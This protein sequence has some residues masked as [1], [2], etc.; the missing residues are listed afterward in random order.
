MNYFRIYPEYKFIYTRTTGT[1]FE[2]LMSFYKEVASHEDFSKDY[3]GLGDLRGANMDLSPEQSAE[4]AR[5]VVASDYTNARWVFLVSEPAATALTMV[6]QGI[7]SRKHELF[8]V[9]TFE[10]ASEY[11][12][13]DFRTFIKD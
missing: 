1:D 9:S 7:V 5:Y 8:V 13:L 12:G 11:L 4:L 2:T 6:Y 10:A 3:V